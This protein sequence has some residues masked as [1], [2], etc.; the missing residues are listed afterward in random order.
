MEA[1]RPLPLLCQTGKAHPAGPV[2]Q[3]FL[4]SD[5]K[6]AIKGLL[7]LPKNP[8]FRQ[9]MDRRSKGRTK[10]VSS[11]QRTA[12]V[13]QHCRKGQMRVWSLSEMP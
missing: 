13:Y 6:A 5:R 12:P 1:A 10:L 2:L 7:R 3:G 4:K 9:Q 8:F 11:R